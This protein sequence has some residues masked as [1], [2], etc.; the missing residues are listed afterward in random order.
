MQGYLGWWWLFTTVLIRYGTKIKNY[1]L[2]GYLYKSSFV[3]IQFINYILARRKQRLNIPDRLFRTA[4][5]MA[6]VC[7]FM[8]IAFMFKLSVTNYIKRWHSPFLIMSFL[9]Y[10]YSFTKSGFTAKAT[11]AGSSSIQRSFLFKVTFSYL[12]KA[13]TMSLLILPKTSCLQLCN[14]IFIIFNY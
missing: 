1:C 5:R 4:S 6:A 2:S 7:S 8:I 13:L 3:F 10:L 12:F 11:T 14:M 9:E